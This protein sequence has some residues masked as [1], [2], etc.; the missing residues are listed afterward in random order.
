MRIFKPIMPRGSIE[1][2]TSLNQSNKHLASITIWLIA[3][4]I[5]LE[6]IKLSRVAIKSGLS[7]PHHIPPNPNQTFSIKNYEKHWKRKEMIEFVTARVS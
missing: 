2:L 5:T 7:V 1:S 4:K 3:S 6:A